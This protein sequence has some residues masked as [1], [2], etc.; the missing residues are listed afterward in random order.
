MN[1]QGIVHIGLRLNNAQA[2]GTVLRPSASSGIPE[3]VEHMLKLIIFLSAFLVKS[4]GI[5]LLEIYKFKF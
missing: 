1:S 3:K 5:T 2:N 4:I